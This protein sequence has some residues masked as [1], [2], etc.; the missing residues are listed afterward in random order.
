MKAVTPQAFVAIM[1]L[2]P[3]ALPQASTG[4][5]DPASQFQQLNMQD[6][7]PVIIP[8]HLQ[9]PEA[10]QTHL[11]FGSFRDDLSTPL[12]T[13]FASEEDNRT[14]AH[15]EDNLA[16]PEPP[17]EHFNA[18]SLMNS[19]STSLEQN[20]TSQSTASLMESFVGSHNMLVSLPANVIS[21]VTSQLEGSKTSPISQQISQYTYL[22]GV[23]NYTS[24]GIMPQLMGTQYN[25]EVAESQKQNPSQLPRFVVSHLYGQ[26]TKVWK[27]MDLMCRAFR[28]AVA[29]FRSGNKLLH[30]IIATHGRR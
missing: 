29:T 7:Q 3:P 21:P 25:H 8:N 14:S 16:G 18:S 4:S 13:N 10:E 1:R 12:S 28:D 19:A 22:S 2:S 6:D 27:G 5:S 23:P 26:I 11:S 15:I 17:S 9:V 24:F 20:D 30:T